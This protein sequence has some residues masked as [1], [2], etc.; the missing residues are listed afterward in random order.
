MRQEVQHWDDIVARLEIVAAGVGIA[1]LQPQVAIKRIHDN[2]WFDGA[3]WASATPVNLTMAGVANADGLYEYKPGGTMMAPED[4]AYKGYIAIVK[5]TS[6]MIR[7]VIHISVP[8]DVWRQNTDL[9]G[10]NDMAGYRQRSLVRLLGVG[11][12]ATADFRYVASA[13]SASPNGRFYGG[14]APSST[15]SFAFVNRNAVLR[16]ISANRSYTVKITAIANDGT[17]YFQ[18]AT[19]DGSPFPISIAATDELFV[20]T[21]LVDASVTFSPGAV[22]D[23]LQT[24]HTVA[25]SF[26]DGFRR[27]LALRQENMRVVYTAWNAARVPTAGTI[28]LYPSKAALDADPTGT[29]AGSFGSYS[30]TATFDATTLEPQNYASGKL[31]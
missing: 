10:D 4:G 30:F 5:E 20:G 26:G 13:P 8:Y 12:G 2:Q 18:L 28:Y 9:Y 11:E 7:E 19:L 27:M 14:V 24:A 17:D 23:Q 25:G 3:N 16:S 31:T 21:S 1:G 15:A 22:W 6:R 29:G